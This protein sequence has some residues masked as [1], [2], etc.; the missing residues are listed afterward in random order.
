M[1][2]TIINPSFPNNPML[3][4]KRKKRLEVLNKQLRTTISQMNNIVKE[5]NFIELNAG[6]YFDFHQEPQTREEANQPIFK[7]APKDCKL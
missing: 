1:I 6:L 4:Q 3:E 5:I 7:T 2:D